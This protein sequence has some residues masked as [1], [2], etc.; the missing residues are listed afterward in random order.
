MGGL[1]PCLGAWKINSI[2]WV[3]CGVC[4][5]RIITQT[6]RDAK[7]QIPDLTLDMALRIVRSAMER[8]T[9][10]FE[11]ALELIKYHGKRNRQAHKSHR[12]SWLDKH[13]SVRKKVML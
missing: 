12:K 4:S 8:P 2:P 6:R 7:S 9:L 13:K 3:M 10:T 11:D 5:W 1:R